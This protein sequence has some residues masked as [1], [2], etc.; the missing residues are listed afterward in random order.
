MISREERLGRTFVEVADTL[1][2]DFDIV[3]LLV[4][5]AERC[6]ELLDA[7]AAGLLLADGRGVLHLMAATSE[8]TEMVELFQIQNDEG[9]CLE[10]FRSGLP[11]LV[12]DLSAE[13]ER[14]PRFA[15]VA[16]DAGFR[17]AHALPLRLRS[18][19]LGA[20]NLFRAEQGRLSRPDVTTAQALADIATIAI[21]QHRAVS[22]A[23][24]LNNQL[25][26]ALNS[27]I[28]IEQS[29]GMI[30]QQLSLDM[31]EAFSMLRHHAR[32]HHRRLSDLATDVIDG[33]MSPS[34]L[35]KP[36]PRHH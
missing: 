33:K 17:A 19:T 29:K 1:V 7:S 8:Q 15:P 6:V 35:D 11:V 5:V 16:G 25:G 3:D 10:C 22:Q 24:E 30:A 23:Q 2:D 31:D 9:P 26:Q 27:R 32:S 28:V 36:S 13:A 20:L 12:P 14:W 34:L 18:N 4:L 21:L